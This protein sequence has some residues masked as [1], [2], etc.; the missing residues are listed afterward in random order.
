MPTQCLPGE[1]LQPQLNLAR[2]DAGG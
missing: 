2:T 1:L